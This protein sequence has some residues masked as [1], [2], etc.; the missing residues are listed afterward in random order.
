MKVVIIEDE[1]LSAEH[2]ALLL[3][4]VDEHIEVVKYLDTVKSIVNSFKEGLKAELIFMD[5]HLADGNCFEVFS[6]IEIEVPIIFTTAYDNYAIQ[7][8]KQ[9]SIDYLLKPISLQDLQFAMNKYNKQQH[10]A[11]RQQF[12]TFAKTYQQLNNQY[13]TRFIVKVGETIDTVQ[14]NEIHHFETKESLSFLVTNKGKKYIIEYT[15]DQLEKLLPPQDFFRI[16]R[17]IIIHIQAIEKVK[18]YFNSRLSITANKLEGDS[19]IVSRE[20]VIEF[21]KWL[22]S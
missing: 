2:L 10:T 22:D 5:I 15:L 20:R 17:K 4:K 11:N 19:Q 14:T 3:K 6:Q 13:K 7:A 16:N 8:F 9:N 12:E 18:T 21:K 1:K